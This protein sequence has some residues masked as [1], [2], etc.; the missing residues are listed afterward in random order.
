MDFVRHIY[1]ERND[2]ADEAAKRSLEQ[3]AGY[4][5]SPAMAEAVSG[6]GGSS[7]RCQYQKRLL[8][9][10]LKLHTAPIT[11]IMG[12]TVSLHLTWDLWLLTTL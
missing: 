11:I 4:L 1:R 7:V 2:L 8:L 3:R 6:T 12:V 5:Q 10:R 9:H